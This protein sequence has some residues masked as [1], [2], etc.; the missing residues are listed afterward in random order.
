MRPTTQALP[1]GYYWL[2]AT[3]EN[4]LAGCYYCNTVR[5][6]E[7]VDGNRRSSGKGTRFPLEDETTRAEGPG[8]E[9][10]E[11]PLLLH[12]YHDEPAQHLE[13]VE[14]GV[15]RARRDA[16]NIPSRRGNETIELLGLNRRGLPERRRKHLVELRY[17]RQDAIE[18]QHAWLDNPDDEDL[19]RSHQEAVAELEALQDPRSGY[20]GL[21]AQFLGL[22]K[23]AASP[24]HPIGSVS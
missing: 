24:S 7:Q 17:A 20:C 18:A 10:R 13:F 23:D 14:D 15:V 11:R 8:D 9:R 2:A 4:L 21:T 12:P 3:W 1:D 6:M 19:A 16:N 5:R 22:T